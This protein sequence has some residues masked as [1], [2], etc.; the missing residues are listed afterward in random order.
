MYIFDSIK[1]ILKDFK[2]WGVLL[3]VKIRFLKAHHGDC[4]LVTLTDQQIIQRILIDGGPS[5]TFKPRQLGDQRDGDLKK[6]LEQLR[7]NNQKIDLVILTHIDDDHIGGLIKAFEDPNSLSKIALKVIFNSYQ[8]IHEDFNKT[9]DIN[10]NILGNF[11]LNNKTSV[12][13]GD[14]LEKFLELNNIWDKRIYKQLDEYN[15]KKGKIKF[16]SPNETEL[17]K[18]LV[19]WEKEI[20]SPFTSE[21][22][23]D[24]EKTYQELLEIDEFVEDDSITNGSS[25]SFI[26]E[27]DDKNYV[28]LGDAYPSTILEGL[29]KIGYDESNPLIAEMIKISH[30]GSKKNTSIELLKSLRSKCFVISTNGSRHGLPNKVTLARVHSEISDAIIYFNYPMIMEKIYN[31]K[32]LN[33]L[34]WRVSGLE[35]ELK[36]DWHFRNNIF[37]Y[38]ESRWW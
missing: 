33:E 19:K 12:K 5:Y 21:H 30:H 4:I 10:N 17:K 37:S 1:Y 27:I 3:S 9:I 15:L 6:V 2:I 26:L 13:Q 24:W 20:E 34:D 23:T 14:T 32:E 31:K 8:L 25:V 22:K 35:E 11:T 36:F 18:L 28:F 29:K 16:L 7:A 38:S